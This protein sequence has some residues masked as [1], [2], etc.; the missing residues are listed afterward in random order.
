MCFQ[1]VLAYYY[2]CDKSL[3]SELLKFIKYTV[4]EFQKK[5]EGKNRTECFQAASV[6]FN[7]DVS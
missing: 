6:P 5:R 4:A 3:C 2:L 7:I 1:K